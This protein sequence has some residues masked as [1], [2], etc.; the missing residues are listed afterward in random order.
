MK[1]VISASRRTDLVA[2][3]P[4]WLA[5][6][7]EKREA[8][9]VGPSGREQRIGLSPE[10]V[11]TF[12]L[13]SKNFSSLLGNRAGLRPLLEA[14]DQLYFHFTVTGLG[15]TEIETGAPSFEEA[16]AQLPALV[17]LAG[18]PLRVSLRFDPILF[19]R[20]G[21]KVE[22]NARFFV[23]AADAA[24][25]AGIRDIRT[26]FAQWYRKARTR[27]VR[28]GFRFIDPPQDEKK[29]WAARF[30]QEASMRGL[31]LYACSQGYLSCVEGLEPSACIDGRLLSDL[32][33]RGESASL[34][35][36]RSQRAEC[37]CTVSKDIGSYTQACPHG[38]VYC[39]A[40][41]AV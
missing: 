35:R 19:W 25:N 10:S 4:D 38:C 5:D 40:N 14:Y 26:S 37:L 30:V 23:R 21:E 28:R 22:T 3:F 2:F 6:C 24:T 34:R 9:I 41:P 32:H 11:H 29:T 36:D 15:G 18:N 8:R 17:D 7:L 39:Y 12:V 1:S 20:E 27:A 31:K 16:L 33:P 13:W